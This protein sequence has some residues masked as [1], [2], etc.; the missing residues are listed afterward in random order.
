MIILANAAN[1]A[2]TGCRR[3][4]R[5]VHPRAAGKEEICG[6]ADREN[7]GLADGDVLAVVSDSHVLARGATAAD[8]INGLGDDIAAGDSR[9]VVAGGRDEYHATSEAVFAAV[10]AMVEVDVVDRRRRAKV[11]LPPLGG[12]ILSVGARATAIDAVPV[13]VDA[14]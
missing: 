11:N 5:C 4:R 12:A 1:F 13:A 9:C 6:T 10:G 2:V 7:L 14:K 3:T 8:D